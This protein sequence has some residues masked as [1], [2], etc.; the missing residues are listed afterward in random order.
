M[1]NTVKRLH[2]LYQKSGYSYPKLEQLTGISKSTLQRYFTGK[3]KKYLQI[4]SLL[5][6]ISLT[7]L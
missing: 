6:Q 7:Y 1:E 4:I 3:T 2:E 5:S